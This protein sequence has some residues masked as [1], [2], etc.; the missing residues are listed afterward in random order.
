MRGNRGP[1]LP[2]KDVE[3]GGTGTVISGDSGRYF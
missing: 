2:K 1:A 3:A